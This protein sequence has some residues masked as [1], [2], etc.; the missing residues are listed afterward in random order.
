[1]VVILVV[2]GPDKLPE[3]ARTVGRTVWQMKHL[4]EELRREASLPSL[5]D[6]KRDLIAPPKSFSASQP[7]PDTAGSAVMAAAAPMEPQLQGTCEATR[8]QPAEP[9][10]VT[11]VTESHAVGKNDDPDDHTAD[12]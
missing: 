7:G 5:E 2:V 8:I 9:T 4:L 12:C 1:M 11:P 10:S 6:I 3:A